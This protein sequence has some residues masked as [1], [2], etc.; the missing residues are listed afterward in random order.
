[1]WTAT[2]VT[3][4]LLR[5]DLTGVAVKAG[6]NGS[7][8]LTGMLRDP[9]TATWVPFTGGKYGCLQDRLRRADR[10]RGSKRSGPATDAR[11]G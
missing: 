2:G 3:P 6:T 11:V 10:C 9:Y 7:L 5:R 4:D 1:M 8:V